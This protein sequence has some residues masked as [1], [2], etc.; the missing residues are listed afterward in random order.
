SSSVLLLKTGYYARTI[1]RTSSKSAMMKRKKLSAKTSISTQSN[2]RIRFHTI[3]LYTYY[4]QLAGMYIG[5]DRYM[6]AL[7]SQTEVST[8]SSSYINVATALHAKTTIKTSSTAKMRTKSFTHDP[9][10]FTRSEPIFIYGRSD[11]RLGL[12]L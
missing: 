4:T 7:R 3:E 11:E 10:R 9:K 12:V 8:K 2:S 5:Y 6:K 1:I